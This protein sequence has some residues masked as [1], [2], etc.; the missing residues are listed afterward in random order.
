MNR[1][2]RPYKYSKKTQ[3]IS[4]AVSPEAYKLFSSLKPGEKSEKVSR[5]IEKYLKNDKEK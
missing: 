4:V 1:V 2:G 5:L 3:I